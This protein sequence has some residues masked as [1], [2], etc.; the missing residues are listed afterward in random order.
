MKHWHASL[1]M[2]LIGLFVMVLYSLRPIENCVAYIVSGFIFAGAGISG[3]W[4]E[5]SN[6]RSRKSRSKLS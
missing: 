1:L 3:I 2:V 5:W 6:V 4:S